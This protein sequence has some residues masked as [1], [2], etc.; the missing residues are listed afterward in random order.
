MFDLTPLVRPVF[1]HWAAKSAG[2]CDPAGVERTQRAV[3]QQLLHRG[4]DTVYGR[5]YGFGLFGGYEDFAGSVPV[6]EYEDIRA[7]V[8]RMVAGEASVLWPGECRRYAQSS[9]TSGGKSKYIPV[10]DAALRCNH[11]AGSSMAVAFYLANYPDSRLFG[12]KAF[13]LGGSYANELNGLPAGTRVGDLSASLI[14]CITPAVNLL[15]V[16]SKK[17]ALM[18]DWNEKLPLLVENSF[19]QNITNISGVPSWFM[20]VLRGVMER[21]GA[22]SIHDVWPN[23]E[24]FFHGGI[25]FAPYRSQYE[26]LCGPAMRFVE[27]YNASEGFFATQDTCAGGAMR[28]LPD[29]GVFYEF[30]PLGGG[31]PVPAWQAE[32]GEVYSLLI[33]ACNGLWRYAIG[34]TVRIECVEPLRISIA[35]RTKCFINAFGEE[36]MVWNADAALDAACRRTGAAVADYTA[37]PVYATEGEKGRHQWFIEWTHRPDC[38]TVAFADIL[39]SELQRVNSDYQ[40]KRTGGIFLGRPEIVDMPAGLFDRWLASTG[41]LGGQRKIPRLSNDRRVADALMHMLSGSSR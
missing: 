39:D 29:I 5:R 25:S 8:M 18:S 35:G 32:P 7:D 4:A 13:I 41:K 31:T 3:L 37:A 40:A 21:A 9:G 1:R 16:P 33:S 26:S 34:D 19:R 30:Q 38:G 10:T 28:L 27:N 6:V 22:D 23:L 24:V 17:I 11:Y 36:L 12:G 2:W 20:T 14:D 15:R